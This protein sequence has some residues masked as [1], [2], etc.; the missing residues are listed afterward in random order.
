MHAEI[1]YSR[2]SG[3]LTLIY[4]LCLTWFPGFGNG[5]SRIWLLAMIFSKAKWQ[6]YEPVIVAF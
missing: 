1:C 6:L 2:A 5:D 3:V 4:I